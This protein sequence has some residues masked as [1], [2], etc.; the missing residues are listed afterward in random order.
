MGDVT[1]AK[2]PRC[3]SY[4]PVV[5]R[6]IRIE[7]PRTDGAVNGFQGMECICRSCDFSIAELGSIYQR[8]MAA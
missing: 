1:H 8:A 5:W 3:N 7:Q 2:C 4:Q 6:A